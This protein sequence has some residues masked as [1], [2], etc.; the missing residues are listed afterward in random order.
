MVGYCWHRAIQAIGLAAAPLCFYFTRR[1]TRN[2]L[3]EKAIAVNA[4]AVS[5]YKHARQDSNLQPTD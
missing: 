1:F 4:Y 2:F 5:V 3:P